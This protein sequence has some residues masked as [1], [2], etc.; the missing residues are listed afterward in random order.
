MQNPIWFLVSMVSIALGFSPDLAKRIPGI[1]KLEIVTNVKEKSLI[2]DELVMGK[3]IAHSNPKSNQVLLQI[4]HDG[5]FR[6]C[7]EGY[8]EGRWISGKFN[9]TGTTI[10]LAL[11]RQYFGPAHDT[12]LTGDMNE[13]TGHQRSMGD[14]ESK[15]TSRR[16]AMEQDL[17]PLSF[18][19]NVAIGKFELA[20]HHPDFFE[21]P[22]LKGEQVVGSFDL[23][24]MLSFVLALH[25]KDAMA[26]SSGGEVSGKQDSVE[27]D[28]GVCDTAFQ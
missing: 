27:P 6:Q 21:A 25:G 14:T 23:S 8:Q 19:G 9:L 17:A 16:D 18:S 22:V 24:Q 2:R 5:S 20:K 13:A 7:N 1:W 3:K 12:L 11:D 26:R 10:R 15:S 4:Q 28:D